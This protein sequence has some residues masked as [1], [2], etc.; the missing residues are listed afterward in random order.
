MNG[1]SNQL[2][3][4]DT[5]CAS[6]LEWVSRGKPGP[7]LGSRVSIGLTPISVKTQ[8]IDVVIGSERFHDVFAGIHSKR[9][10]PGEDGLLG[11]GILSKYTVTIDVADG[12]LL[13]EKR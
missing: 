8:A 1:D 3:R 4:V 2:V 6:A 12:Q 11:N 5:G 10:F 7:S 9:L 13:L